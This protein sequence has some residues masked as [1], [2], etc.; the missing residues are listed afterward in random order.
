VPQAGPAVHVEPVPQV[1][2]ASAAA[3]PSVHVTPI[4]VEKTAD[5]DA[6]APE[7]NA[8]EQKVPAEKPP[9]ATGT[10]PA[11]AAADD[12]STAALKIVDAKAH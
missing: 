8:P 2:P 4:P 1:E 11:P 5:A 9:A 7:E 6:A 12:T 10:P 3:M